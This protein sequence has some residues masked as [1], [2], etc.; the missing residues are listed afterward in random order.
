[1]TNTKEPSSWNLSSRKAKEKH[2]SKYNATW[3]N[4]DCPQCMLPWRRKG[5]VRMEGFILMILF[6]PNHHCWTSSLWYGQQGTSHYTSQ[7]V[8]EERGDG[9]EGR[10][11]GGHKRLSSE[12]K[13]LKSTEF[14]QVEKCRQNFSYREWT[15]QKHPEARKTTVHQKGE[16]EFAPTSVNR[17]TQSNF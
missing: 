10:R 7:E 13:K 5:T 3:E 8:T 16:A 12:V 11:R 1:M 4:D 6:M 14:S 17:A 15:R 9:A 2:R